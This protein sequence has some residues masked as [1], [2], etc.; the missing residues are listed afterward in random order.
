MNNTIQSK[1]W[2]ISI[3]ITAALFILSLIA[4]YIL[5]NFLDSS[6]TFENK[7]VNLGGAAAGFVIIFWLLRN[8]FFKIDTNNLAGQ[9]KDE[10]IHQ[11]ELKIKDLVA[12]KLDN[13]IVPENYTAEISNEFKFGFCYPKD[14][15]FN[16]FP[17][18]TFYGAAI[19]SA[20]DTEQ[21]FHRNINIVISDISHVEEDLTSLYDN[22]YNS[23]LAFLPNP[24][25]ISIEDCLLNGLPAKK[26]RVNYVNNEGLALTLYQILI[27][28]KNKTN[29]YAISFTVSQANF[30]NSKSLFDNMLST[31]RV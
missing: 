24:T 12:A 11:L 27:A 7:T 14:W 21:A 10:Q 3:C 31:L 25:P 6:A 15:N 20:P 18:Q 1:T 19:D 30:E 17:Q 8:T 28:D 26:Y 16:K 2:K 5:F 9:S 22:G 23:L 29:L 4:A 13:F